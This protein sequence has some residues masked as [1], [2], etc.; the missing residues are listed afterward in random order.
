MTTREQL[1]F[2]RFQALSRMFEQ[3]GATAAGEAPRP[4]D[5][6]ALEETRD[7]GHAEQVRQAH[8]AGDPPPD[9][10]GDSA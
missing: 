4:E 8:A 1:K 3:D 6:A 9:F 7:L 10:S 2:E 5:F